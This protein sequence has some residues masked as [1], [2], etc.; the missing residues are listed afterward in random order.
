VSEARQLAESMARMYGK[1]QAYALADRYARDCTAN[2]DHQ[3][4]E[5]WAMAAA[6]VGELIDMDVGRK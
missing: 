3:G 1:K 5:K 6:L 2:G 4:H